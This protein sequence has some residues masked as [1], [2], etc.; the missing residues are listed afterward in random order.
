MSTSHLHFLRTSQTLGP[1]ASTLY[2]RPIGST[3]LNPYVAPGGMT[4]LK[5]GLA[6]LDK[7]I[8]G[9][10]D[11]LAPATF[12][13]ES[14]SELMTKYGFRTEGRDVARPECKEQGAFPGFGTEY[15]QVRAEP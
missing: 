1:T 5:D 13:D 10:G 12:G 8:C 14:L 11:P 2:P 6:V 15:P 7:N 4:K 9:Y 3:R